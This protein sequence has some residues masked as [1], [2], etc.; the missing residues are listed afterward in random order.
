MIAAMTLKGLLALVQIVG[1]TQGIQFEAF[2][3]RVLVPLLWD[4]A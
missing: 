3:A 2:I 4:G 1:S